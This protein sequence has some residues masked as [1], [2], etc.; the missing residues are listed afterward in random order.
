MDAAISSLDPL[1]DGSFL[2]SKQRWYQQAS[3]FIMQ[4]ASGVTTFGPETAEGPNDLASHAAELPEAAASPTQIGSVWVT[5]SRQGCRSCA[6]IWTYL[7]NHNCN[8]FLRPK[9]TKKIHCATPEG[10]FRHF[11]W[12]WMAR[13]LTFFCVNCQTQCRKVTLLSYW[14]VWLFIVELVLNKVVSEWKLAVAHQLVP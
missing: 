12:F 9:R 14:R 7:D 3:A 8:W 6:M 4:G 13:T 11:N 5:W 1:N 2:S 10:H